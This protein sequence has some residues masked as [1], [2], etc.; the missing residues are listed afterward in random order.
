VLPLQNKNAVVSAKVQE[1]ADVG[2]NQEVVADPTALKV[3]IMTADFWGLK[4]AGGTATVYHLLA[5]VLANSKHIHVSVAPP[6][7]S[8]RKFMLTTPPCSPH[9]GTEGAPLHSTR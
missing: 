1:A 9:Y 3:C 5:A 7:P 8:F 2:A 6:P 4:S